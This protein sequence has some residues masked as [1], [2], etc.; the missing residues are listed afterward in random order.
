MKK[1]SSHNFS[2]TA[3]LIISVL[4][5]TTILSAC[6]SQAPLASPTPRDPS[7]P[8]SFSK[9]IMPILQTSC[10]KCH[11][12]EKVSRGLDLTA[13]DK[14]MTGSIKGP[15]VV[16]GNADKS[17]LFTLI[18]QGKMPKQGQKLSDAQVEI[19]RSWIAAGAQNN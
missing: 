19:M 17:M 13:Y 4:S 1:A 5:I 18:Q 7:L 12:V 14:L 15:V 3:I 16:P 8:V 2:S 6:G 9:D 10:V 11:G